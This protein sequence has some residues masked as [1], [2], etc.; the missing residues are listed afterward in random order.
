MMTLL[1]LKARG[2]ACLSAARTPVKAAF[3]IRDKSVCRKCTAAKPPPHWVLLAPDSGSRNRP[4]PPQPSVHSPPPRP[5]GSS[6]SS[7]CP[8]FPR[9]LGAL[10]ASLVTPCVGPLALF[11]VDSVAPNRRGAGARGA[12]PH[13][14]AHALAP[15]ADPRGAVSSRGSLR[16]RPP[17]VSAARAAVR[18]S[19][20]AT[21][22]AGARRV[23]RSGPHCAG[24]RAAVSA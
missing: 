10:V 16:R 4:S 6:A 19:A 3:S 20:D 14:R 9:F 15:R 11:S 13:C 12:T 7:W 23:M 2:C 8:D 1:S 5:P 24:L 22:A 18:G 17:M 21:R